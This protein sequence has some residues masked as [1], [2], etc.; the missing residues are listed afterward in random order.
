MTGAVSR[1]LRYAH[2]HKLVFVSIHM[3]V[4]KG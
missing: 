4:L 1:N 2:C 3:Q